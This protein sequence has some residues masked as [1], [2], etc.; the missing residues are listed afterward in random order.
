VRVLICASHTPRGPLNGAALVLREIATRLAS[1]HAVTVIAYRWPGQDGPPPPGV[2]LHELRRPPAAWPARIAQHA[3]GLLQDEPV[4]A[5]RLREPMMRA[6]RTCRAA[7]SFDVAH[8]MLGDL[9]SIAPALAGIPAIVAPLDA[10]PD[11]VAAAAASAGPLRRAWLGGQA[12]LVRRYVSRAYRPFRRVVLVSREDEDAV[13]R[14]DPSLDTEVVA[15]GVDVDYFSPA[16]SAARDRRLLLFTGALDFPPNALAARYLATEI[17]PRV[18][19]ARPDARL[20]V[21]GRRPGAS[22]RALAHQPGVEVHADVDD[23]R[24]LLR[25]AGV[26]ACAMTW[27]T[28]IKNKLLEAMACGA[29]AVATSLGCRGLNVRDGQ[30]VLVADTAETFAASVARVLDDDALADG[31]ARSGRAYV[32]RHHSWDAAARRYEAIYEDVVAWREASVERRGE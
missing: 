28:G 22:V 14:L 17:L 20:V 24:P 2:T 15:N 29:P 30:E 31:L 9:A 32:T 8:V 21:A 5:S 11:N 4:D 27:G 16:A 7:Q 18:Q 26:F 1:R 13:R 23:L 25:T 3:W 12:R 6:V 10:W 19:R